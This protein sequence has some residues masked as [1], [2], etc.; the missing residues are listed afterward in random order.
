MKQSPNYGFQ[1]FSILILMFLALLAILVIM[2]LIFL[3]IS[4]HLI[5]LIG[6]VIVPVYIFFVIIWT[7]HNDNN[8]MYVIKNMIKHLNLKGD[9][10]VLDLGTGAGPV[11]IEFAKQ[12]PKGKVFGLDKYS[13]KND[14]LTR[15]II[16]AA[17]I[18][19]IGHTLNNAQRNAKIEDVYL[20]SFL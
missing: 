15:R 1:L 9:E 11:A 10:I 12:L 14:K 7:N 2:L 16:I 17:K 19:Y 5:L 4:W 20:N 3:C 13:F 8:R 6:V 18:N